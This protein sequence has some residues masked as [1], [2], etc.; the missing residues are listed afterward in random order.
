MSNKKFNIIGLIALA[1]ILISSFSLIVYSIPNSLTL[2][3]KLTNLTGMAK[4]VL[5]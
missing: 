1:V 5:L 4:V 2:Q 3:G